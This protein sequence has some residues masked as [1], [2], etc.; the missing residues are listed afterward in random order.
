[1]IVVTGAAGFIGSNIIKGLNQIGITDILAVDDLTDGKKYRN[2]AVVKYADYMDYRD[3]LK[4]ITDTDTDAEIFTAIFHQGA[5]SDTTEWNGEYMMQNNYAY[6]KSVLHFCLAKKIPFIYA[7]S[8]AVY[9]AKDNF[10]DQDWQQ[11]PLNV[12][13]YSKWKFDEYVRPYLNNTTSQIVGLRYF[14]VYGPHENHKGK[15]ASVAFHLMNQLDTHNT[16]KL[17]S[18][19]GGYGDGEHERD[20]IFVDDIVKLNLWFYRNPLKSGIFNAGAGQARCF[21][22]IAKKLIALNGGGKLEYVPF[23]ETLK[24]AYQSFTQANNRALRAIGYDENFTSLE[25]GLAQYFEWF[26]GEGKYHRG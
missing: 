6:S 23:P 20:F 7:S 14:N 18:R 21:N 24:G 11:L 16:V 2:L 3:F 25:N 5:C 19:Y 26:R 10:D 1:M 22:D 9:G 4:M 8:A 17:F 13:G 15:M 12:Y